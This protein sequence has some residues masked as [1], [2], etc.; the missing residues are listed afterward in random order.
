MDKKR[1]I[2][3]KLDIC[4]TS[5]NLLRFI[6]LIK[7]IKDSK[8]DMTDL[9][10]SKYGFSKNCT[11]MEF[12][13]RY[14]FAIISQQSRSLNIIIDILISFYN[15]DILLIKNNIKIYNG[16]HLD[17]HFELWHCKSFIFDYTSINGDDEKLKKI[18]KFNKLE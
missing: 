12:F 17:K 16:Q 14:Y 3:R 15:D 7:E 18:I 1:D 10:N 2:L 9:L 11:Y 5:R 6:E 8:Y 13:I 4:V